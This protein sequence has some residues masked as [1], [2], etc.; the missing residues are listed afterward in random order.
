MASPTPKLLIALL[1]TL[2]SAPALA[3]KASPGVQGSGMMCCTDAEGRR[4]CGSSLPRQCTGRAY[5]VYNH[6]GILTQEVGPPPTPAEKAAKAEAERQEK[7]AE[8]AAKEQ[9][10]KDIALQETYTSVQDIDRMQARAEADTKAAIAAA[11]F[12]IAEAQKRRKKFEN[13]AE[14]Y[15]NRPLPPSVAKGLRE[16]E[17]EIK[18]QTELI[19]VKKR[20]LDQMHIKYDEDRR[21][22]LEL[23]RRPTSSRQ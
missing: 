2:L 12:K 23:S 8:A 5:K 15:R 17:V 16:E 21:R 1:G 19:D 10:R 7:A 9:K 22:Y 20:D 18:S 14:F 6:Q 4:T 11:E 13:E 3:Q